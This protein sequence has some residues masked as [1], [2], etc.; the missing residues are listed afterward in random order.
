MSAAKVFGYDR[1]PRNGKDLVQG[2]ARACAGSPLQNFYVRPAALDRVETKRVRWQAQGT[3]HRRARSRLRP[4]AACGEP[5]CP[6]SRR[7][8]PQLRCPDLHDK[9]AEHLTIGG[10]FDRHGCSYAVQR[11]RGQQRDRLP[12]A[13]RKRPRRPILRWVHDCNAAPWPSSLTFIDKTKWARSR[14]FTVSLQ[15]AR[16]C[17]CARVSR[18]VACHIVFSRQVQALSHP[19][20]AQDT[21]PSLL[22]ALQPSDEFAQ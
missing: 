6:R 4:R 19:S 7:P 5:D 21:E 17:R 8:G 14:A 3:C 2:V 12:G 9:G 13:E 1:R 16:R 22:F 15:S 11:R 10:G 18:S 20:Q